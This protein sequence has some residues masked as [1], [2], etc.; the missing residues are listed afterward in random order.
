MTP[1]AVPHCLSP[2]VVIVGDPSGDEAS[3]CH[4]H[5]VDMARC[6][7]GRIKALRLAPPGT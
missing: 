5:W 6:S 4:W 3:V 2:A 7:E 1:C